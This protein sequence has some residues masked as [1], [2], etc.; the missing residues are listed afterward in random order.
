MATSPRLPIQR[1]Q[2]LKSTRA[3]PAA[4]RRSKCAAA[5]AWGSAESS[6]R[7]NALVT[8]AA[9]A[10]FEVKAGPTTP[11]LY[12]YATVFHQTLRERSETKHA[13]FWSAAHSASRSCATDHSELDRSQ[14]IYIR[15]DSGWFGEA[16]QD[17]Y[18]LRF[19]IRPSAIGEFQRS[20]FHA[21]LRE[22]C[23]A[24]SA[25]NVDLGSAGE[26]TT[27]IGTSRR[28]GNTFTGRGCITFRRSPAARS[29]GPRSGAGYG[30]L[31]SIAKEATGRAQSPARPRR[32]RGMRNR[33]SR[34]PSIA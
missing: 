18:G 3:P 7:P 33:C 8:E 21:H 16:I 26:L 6:R 20:E 24:A 4:S 11:L 10:E 15:F 12:G 28:A 23:R 13:R 5:N 32:T 1:T 2:T 27:T 31:E 25:S 30:S 34:E 17:D 29:Q 14:Q 19:E 9:F 22:R